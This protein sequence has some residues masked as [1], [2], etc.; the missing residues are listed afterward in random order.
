[1]FQSK[2]VKMTTPQRNYKQEIVDLKYPFDISKLK[3]R[4]LLVR[5]IGSSVMTQTWDVS[6]FSTVKFHLS[7]LD[8]QIAKEF[9]GYQ[10]KIYA[11]RASKKGDGTLIEKMKFSFKIDH[12]A[13]FVHV[14]VE[15][16][17]AIAAKAEDEEILE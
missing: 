5:E 3:A 1:M 4:E 16:I 2:I 13:K 10:H 7:Q 14:N 11:Y 17:P 12:H 6:L 15:L 9:P 8:R